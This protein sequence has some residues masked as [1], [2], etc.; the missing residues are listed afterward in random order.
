MIIASEQNF[1]PERKIGVNSISYSYSNDP[2]NQI[3]AIFNLTSSGFEDLDN[4]KIKVAFGNLQTNSP[5][6][7]NSMEMDLVDYLSGD[8]LTLSIPVDVL[9]GDLFCYLTIYNK[10]QDFI[11]KFEVVFTEQI[12]SN[13]ELLTNNFVDVRAFSSKSIK[14]FELTQKEVEVSLFK[15]TQKDLFGYSYVS[16]LFYSLK[17]NLSVNCFFGVDESGYFTDKNFLTFL[18]KDQNY[19]DYINSNSFIIG[20]EG[21]VYSGQDVSK[22]DPVRTPGFSNIE[23]SFGTLHQINF[24]VNKKLSKDNKFGYRVKLFLKNAITDYSLNVL[25]PRLKAEFNFLNPINVE[26]RFVVIPKSEISST[27]RIVKAIF[28]SESDEIGDLFVFWDN[29]ERIALNQELKDLLILANN[30]IVE[31]IARGNEINRISNSPTIEITKD[32]GNIIDVSRIEVGAEIID[33]GAET[34]TLQEI[35]LEQFTTRAQ[36]EVD[37]FFETGSTSTTIQT[38]SGLTSVDLSSLS[39]GFMSAEALY[40]NGV[41]FFD[42]TRGL[43]YDFDYNDFLSYVEAINKT[44]SENLDYD[45]KIFDSPT[46]ERITPQEFNT[47]EQSKQLTSILNSMVV[48]ELPRFKDSVERQAYLTS[49]SNVVKLFEIPETLRTDVCLDDKTQSDPRNEALTTRTANPDSFIGNNLLYFSVLSKM[50]RFD[51]KKFYEFYRYLLN[52]EINVDQIPVQVAFLYKFYREGLQEPAFLE[53]QNLYENFVVFGLIYFL[54]KHLFKVSIY[55]EEEGGFV[56]L[57]STI[58]NGLVQGQDYLIRLDHYRNSNL[59]V[60]TPNLLMESIYNKHFVI[61][62]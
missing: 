62:A 45:F 25:S 22:I 48:E 53:K 1:I 8:T 17:K 47:E 13:G 59:G 3:R 43:S 5:V 40:A 38:K 35:S 56:K 36:S 34:E 2:S 15:E 19:L 60:E 7:T 52:N 31:L 61:R 54:F 50:K 16:D 33:F 51:D 44:C 29:S 37:K 9:L 4:L 30:N 28:E 27:L 23:T 42:N 57:T 18:N 24:A 39:Y 21:F 6:F 55:I 46:L 12:L 32:F 49:V 10:T 11:Q 14:V 41:K 26:D 20:G 58:L